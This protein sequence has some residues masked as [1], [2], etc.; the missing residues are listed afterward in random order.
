[1]LK[2]SASFVL[3]SLKPSTCEVS[4]RQS[5]YPLACDRS[6]RVKRSLVCTSFGLSLTA[7]CSVKGASRV[8]DCIAIGGRAGENLYAGAGG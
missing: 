3:V 8:N 6:E 1:M 7:A 4:W 5:T 2:K